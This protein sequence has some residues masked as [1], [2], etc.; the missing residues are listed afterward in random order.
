MRD[1]RDAED[2]R[3][4][5]TGE[6]DL[7]LAGWYETIR[8]R[9]RREDARPG[10]RGRRAGGVRAAV[11]R[12]QGGKHRD[13]KQPFRVIV[14]KVIGWVCKGWYEP[15]WQESELFE[16]DGAAPDEA[17][18]VVIEVTLEQFVATL[19]PG[20]GEVARAVLPRRPRA[21]RDRRA[22]RQEAERGLPGDQPEQERSCGSGSRHERRARRPCST[23]SRAAHARGEPLDVEGLLARA[24]DR[25]DELAP[26]IEAF[27]VRAPRRAP[28]AEAL[29][30]VRSLD[31]PPMPART[32]REGAQGRRRRRR[33]RHGVRCPPR[34]AAEGAPLLPAA[35][36]RRAR[37]GRAS[38]CPCGT[39]SP[40]SSAVRAGR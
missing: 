17:D 6:I 9:V 40:G 37:P 7:L 2:K 26:L 31:D 33:D 39:R 20:D 30:Y 14:H 18:E 8:G 19:P 23:S 27:L 11:A 21:R 22:A 25:A 3:L 5:E 24:G 4:L 32:R 15:G 16:I 28:T 35:R 1:A 38:R 12:A 10:R 34:R 36:G 29:A 13:G